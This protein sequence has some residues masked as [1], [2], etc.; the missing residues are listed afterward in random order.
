MDI[1]AAVILTSAAITTQP[2]IS[3]RVGQMI[4]PMT[5]EQL[6]QAT[7]SCLR[8]NRGTI[9]HHTYNDTVVYVSCWSQWSSGSYYHA[10]GMYERQ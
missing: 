4:P 6:E 7:T 8:W 9:V 5:N 1:I 10:G 2:V 3:D